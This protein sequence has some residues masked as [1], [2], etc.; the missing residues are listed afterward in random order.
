MHTS[1]A[2]LTEGLRCRQAAEACA[3]LSGRTL[4]KLPFLAFSAGT[5]AAGCSCPQFMAAL[6]QAAQRETADRALLLA[7]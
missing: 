3:G 2:L 6:L 1:A 4:R 7:S 5:T